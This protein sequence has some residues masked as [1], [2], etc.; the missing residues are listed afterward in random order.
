MKVGRIHRAANSFRLRQ[1]P[2][3][4]IRLW[5]HQL[6]IVH[7]LL[8]HY[9]IPKTIIIPCKIHHKAPTKLVKSGCRSLVFT[10]LNLVTSGRVV[11]GISGL[12]GVSGPLWGHRVHCSSPKWASEEKTSCIH[13]PKYVPKN[14]ASCFPQELARIAKFGV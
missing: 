6:I 7:G 12:R 8:P 13:A 3:S 4:P 9:P 11:E 5:R 14:S 2:P 10:Q 1:L